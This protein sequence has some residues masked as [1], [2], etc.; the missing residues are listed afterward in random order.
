MWSSLSVS[1]TGTGDGS[2]TTFTVTS[3]TVIDVI[4]WFIKWYSSR[5]LMITQY[6]VQL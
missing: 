4:Q 5:V 3:G 6:Q 1:R 2:T